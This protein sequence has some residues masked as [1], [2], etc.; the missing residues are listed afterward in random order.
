MPTEF[1]W[2]RVPTFERLLHR[3]RRLFVCVCG[4]VEV[5][6]E[7]MEGIKGLITLVSRLLSGK[8]DIHKLGSA[9]FFCYSYILKKR[10]LFN[11]GLGVVLEDGGSHGRNECK[12]KRKG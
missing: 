10:Y 11:F 7:V 2:S 1:E 5:G 3:Q 12:E 6:E 8:C 4:K 9:T